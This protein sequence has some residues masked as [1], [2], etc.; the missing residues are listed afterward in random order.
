[1]ASTSKTP[2]KVFRF[3]L[4]SESSRDLSL[5]LFNY[6][7]NTRFYFIRGTVVVIYNSGNSSK[8]YLT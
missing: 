6:P 3:R 8:N 5:F 4:D 1:M 2:M 7:R